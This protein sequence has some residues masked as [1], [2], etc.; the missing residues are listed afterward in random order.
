MRA[1]NEEIRKLKLSIRDT[2]D[3]HKE[4]DR[5]NQEQ[6]LLLLTMEERSRK[7]HNLIH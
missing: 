1:L 4:V 2:Q 5:V 3:R 6:H 7:L